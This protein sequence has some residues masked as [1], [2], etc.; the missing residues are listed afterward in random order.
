MTKQSF[1]NRIR[2]GGSL[3]QKRPK[4]VSQ[5]GQIDLIVGRGLMN[6]LGNPLIGG[7]YAD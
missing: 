4:I 5:V 2:T 3:I 7:E 6:E 1:Q